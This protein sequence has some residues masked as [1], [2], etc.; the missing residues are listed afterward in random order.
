M[1]LKDLKEWLETLSKEELEKPV[2]YYSDE[3]SMSGEINEIMEAGEDLYYLGEDDP[4]QLKTAEE[5]KEDGWDAK[6]IKELI[7][8]IPKDSFCLKI[9]R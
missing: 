8:E 6:S 4:S 7:V 2:L 3:Y 1:K 9:G 5:L